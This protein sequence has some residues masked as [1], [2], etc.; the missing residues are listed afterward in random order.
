MCWCVDV[1]MCWCADVLMCWFV[2]VLMCWCVDVLMCWCVDVLMC[3]CVDVLMCWYVDMLMCWF[4]DVLLCWCVDVLIFWFVDVL[5]GWCVVRL[6]CWCADVLMCWCVWSVECWCVQHIEK[7]LVRVTYGVRRCETS[8]S[9]VCG[10]GG[11]E[12]IEFFCG[13]SIRQGKVFWSAWGEKHDHRSQDRLVASDAW[14]WVTVSGGGWWV[15]W[16]VVVSEVWAAHASK[17]GTVDGNLAGFGIPRASVGT[18]WSLIR[19]LVTTT[20]HHHTP[21]SQVMGWA[22]IQVSTVRPRNTYGH[23]RIFCVQ[24]RRI[25]FHRKKTHTFLTSPPPHT[26][27]TIS[28]VI[29]LSTHLRI[30]CSAQK[31]HRSQ[32]MCENKHTQPTTI[33]HHHNTN[34]VQPTLQN[35]SRLLLTVRCGEIQT[36][37]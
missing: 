32:Q 29:G 2:D 33:H 16:W 18:C 17:P 34:S 8:I 36:T 21:P 19:N 26:T 20:M 12:W 30:G 10:G 35:A 6:M 25:F 31:H 5:F 13:G 1:L 11:C 14:W 7:Y 4:V 27:I 24:K 23:N 28:Q 15:V 3:W 9:Y 22:S 37:T